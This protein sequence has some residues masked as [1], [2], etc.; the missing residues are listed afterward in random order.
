M[1][2]ILEDVF[3]RLPDHPGAAHL[4]IHAYDD[5]RLAARGVRAARVYASIAPD[6]SHAQHMPSHIFIRYGLWDDV[7]KSS[8]RAWA[9]TRAEA[10]SGA[11]APLSYDWH[12]A[13]FLQYGYLQQGRWRDAKLL[14]DSANALLA[15]ARIARA[16]PEERSMLVSFLERIVAQYQRETERYATLSFDEG[17][18]PFETFLRRDRAL[19]DSLASRLES[20]PSTAI[21]EESRRQRLR[22][23]RS[24]AAAISGKPDSAIVLLQRWCQGDLTDVQRAMAEGPRSSGE[25]DCEV[26]GELLIGVGRSAEAVIAYDNALKDVPAHWIARLGRARALACAGDMSGARSAYAELLAQWAHADSDLPALREVR[27]GA[28]VATSPPACATSKSATA[29]V[30]E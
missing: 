27:A 9:M 6:A 17:L 8:E 22:Q 16:K 24:F 15:P 10:G 11:D 30:R 29:T 28:A 25:T 18:Y 4:L 20:A 26:A 2:R 5:A 12:N 7:V 21:T 23:T 3:R 13:D 1:G 14:A 19:M